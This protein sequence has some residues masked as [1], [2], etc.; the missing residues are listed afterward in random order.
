MLEL[1]ELENELLQKIDLFAK[2]KGQNRDTFVREA[3][4]CYIEDLEDIEAAEQVLTLIAKKS[5]I[6]KV[7]G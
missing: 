1:V 6:S 5:P 4:L 3:L 2:S 7:V